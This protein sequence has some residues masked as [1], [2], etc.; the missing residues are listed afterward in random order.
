MAHPLKHRIDAV[1]RRVR[2]LL[3]LHGLSMFVSVVLATV[4]LLAAADFMIRYRD[5][6]VRW[7]CSLAAAAAA[8]WAY[9]RYVHQAL[10][11]RYSDVEVAQRIERRFPELRDRLSSTIEFLRQPE[12]DWRAGSAMLRREVIA[13]TTAD[14]EPLRL[15][16][17]VES[18]PAL[19]A[20]AAAL[21]VSAVTAGLALLDPTAARVA[22]VRLVNPGGDTVWPKKNHLAFTHP[23]RRIALGQRFEVELADAGGAELPDEVR[24]IY[25]YTTGAERGEESVEAMQRV[26]G[27]MVAAKDNVSRPFS[28]RAIGGDDDSMPWIDLE[29]VEPPAVSQLSVEVHPPAYTG[30]APAA[31]EPH[32]RALIGSRIA[33]L[34]RTT[35][36]LRRAVLKVEGGAEVP[37]AIEGDGYGFSLAADAE[38]AFVVERSGAYWFELEDVEGFP[39]GQAVRYDL[40]AIEDRAP[41]VT[42]ERPKADVFV[43]PEAAVPVTV[44]GKD[45]LALQKIA[46]AFSRSDRSE[47]GDGEI[48]LYEG[49]PQAARSQAFGEAGDSR[50]VEH[51]WNLGPLELKPG[52]QVL[53]RATATDYQPLASQSQPRRL[54]V[55]TADELED[56]LTE[57]QTFILGELARIV[58]L[59]Q[60]AR[61]KVKVVQIQAEEVGRLAKGDVDQLQGAELVQRQVDR[62]L[63]GPGEGVKSQ[64]E[65]L[66]ETLANNKIS[67]DDVR[68]RMDELTGAIDRLA[69][70]QL[71]SIARD[72][73]AALKNAQAAIQD[74]PQRMAQVDQPMKAALADAGQRQEQVVAALEQLLGDLADWDHYRRFHRDLNQL[75]RD[76]EELAREAAEAGR[77]TLTRELRDLDPQQQANLKKL[78]QRQFD[79]A[80]RFDKVQQGLEQVLSQLEQG[81]PLAADTVADAVHEARQRAVGGQ[82]REAGRNLEQNQVGQATG[83]QGEVMNDLQELLDI[84]ANR[85]EHELARL[86]KKLREAEQQLVALRK[87]QAGLRKKMEDAAKIAD[88][89]QRKRELERLSRQQ[90]ELQEK[91]DRFARQLQRLQADEAGRTAA[92]AGARMGQAGQQGEEGNASGAADQA[93]AAARDLDDA[94]QQLAT[95]RRQ[96]EADLAD[97]QLARLEEGLQGLLKRQQGLLDE[98]RHYQHLRETQQRWTRPQV[99]SVLDLAQQ[100]QHLESETR[101]QA[102]KLEPVPAFV[103]ALDSAAR[104]MVTARQ[105][106]ARQDTG[107]VTQQAQQ[108]AIRR[109]E[110]LLEALKSESA[111]GQQQEQQQGGEGQEGQQQQAE[112]GVHHLA[113]LKLLK[114]LQQ[115]INLRTREIEESLRGK[116][117]L[118]P[119]ELREYAALSEEQGRLADLLVDLARPAAEEAEDDLGKLLELD[120][121]RPA[122]KVKDQTPPKEPEDLR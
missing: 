62:G 3:T 4:T 27:V 43:T 95:R 19:R 44:L 75:R 107:D 66:L 73:T 32:L 116:R 31:G 55:I 18:R 96:A 115:D 42:L 103:L 60:E 24:I 49:P 46:L 26:A 20:L 122:E 34:G 38:A 80:R 58:K 105:L 29:V 14:V 63:T 85:R 48:V 2:V 28:Y 41:S 7:I 98:T 61:A 91:V 57:K 47:H 13:R 72:L 35:K 23:P 15:S 114:I 94:Q 68:R 112:D 93:A 56:R 50:T 88:E 110:Q 51:A 111:A 54:T 90:R 16:E 109:F 89:A 6:G 52:A 22:L 5:P 113:E 1:R 71:P 69:R 45:D 87:E 106:L 117:Q 78:A 17:A 97:E 11:A 77:Q 39:G 119:E 86:V 102:K 118:S 37:L 79:L 84:L 53:I 64:I 8:G 99:A 67:S 120:G 70:D 81:D 30:W 100:Q 10:A 59:E 104:E 21:V 83:R 25:R 33:L 92:R 76:Q 121:Q 40:R 12:D 36:P 108:R 65:D 74:D 101:G 82:M 9:H